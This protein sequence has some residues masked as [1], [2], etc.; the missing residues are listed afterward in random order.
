M[1]DLGVQTPGRLLTHPDP[2]VAKKAAKVFDTLR[3]PQL[4]QKSALIAKFHGAFAI[5]S[6]RHHGF[7]R[8]VG[9][10]IQWI[11][12]QGVKMKLSRLF[13]RL[14]RWEGLIHENFLFIEMMRCI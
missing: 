6:R 3:G 8:V 7:Q 9:V 13:S 10:K 2:V 1:N 14:S 11:F 4:T 5:T 12:L